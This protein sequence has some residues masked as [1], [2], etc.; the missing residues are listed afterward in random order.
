M[1]AFI[2]EIRRKEDSIQRGIG[3]A[4]T[5]RVR[6]TTPPK[7]HVATWSFNTTQ[8]EAGMVGDMQGFFDALPGGSY[9]G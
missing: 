7:G 6:P 8:D 2:L 5:K 4:T 3:D 1:P 9:A